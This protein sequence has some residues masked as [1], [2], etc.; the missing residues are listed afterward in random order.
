M[1][2]NLY[3]KKSFDVHQRGEKKEAAKNLG[4]EG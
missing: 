4:A 3:K 1:D 2:L